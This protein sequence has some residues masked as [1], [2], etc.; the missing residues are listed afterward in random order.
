MCQNASVLVA[1]HECVRSRGGGSG[2][3]E[4]KKKEKQSSHVHQRFPE[5]DHWILPV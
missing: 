4:R 5:S 3:G 1:T 2:G